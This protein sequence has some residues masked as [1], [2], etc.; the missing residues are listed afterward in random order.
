[1]T[2][3]RRPLPSTSLGRCSPGLGAA[4]E[5]G[6][7]LAIP[8]EHGTTGAAAARA[9]R[10]HPPVVHARSSVVP[11]DLDAAGMEGRTSETPGA[12]QYAVKPPWRAATAAR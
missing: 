10:R 12:A 2:R 3:T 4:L 8:L 9:N 7:R 5:R 1:M 11:L 6:G